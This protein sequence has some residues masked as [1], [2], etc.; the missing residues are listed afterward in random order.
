MKTLKNHTK[1]LIILLFISFSFIETTNAQYLPSA[2]RSHKI[3]SLLNQLKTALYDSSRIKILVK[4]GNI[5]T[6]CV[7]DSA[8]YF[9]DIALTIS[10]RT[11]NKKYIAKT[12]VGIGNIYCKKGEY[13]KSLEIYKKALEIFEKTGDIEEIPGVYHNIGNI[14][15]CLSN[16]EKAVEYYLKSLKIAE[17]TK[18]KREISECLQVLDTT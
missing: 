16:Y 11:D 1:K 5:Y 6:N 9:Y 13:N 14:Y 3:D 7:P 18:N 15:A 8:K 17:K 12:Y 4:I 2:G 10:K